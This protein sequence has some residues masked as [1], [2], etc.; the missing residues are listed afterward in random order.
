M[1]ETRFTVTELRKK[2]IRK[3][4]KMSKLFNFN[5]SI[6]FENKISEI[7]GLREQSRTLV[8]RYIISHLCGS[9]TRKQDLPST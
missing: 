5:K 7:C 9:S 2:H 8:I 1:Y 4:V 6:I 3:S